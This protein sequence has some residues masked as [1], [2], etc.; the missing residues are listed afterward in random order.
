MSTR[1][2]LLSSTAP[3]A[4]APKLIS[5]NALSESLSYA[6]IMKPK[7]RPSAGILIPIK[8][9]VPNLDDG[10]ISALNTYNGSRLTRHFNEKWMGATL[11]G[12]FRFGSVYS[13]RGS[14]TQLQGRF[15]D[16]QEGV[17]SETFR[18]RTG[19]YSG[20]V[21]GADLQDNIISGYDNPVE[22]RYEA[23]DYCS[24][25][26]IGDFDERRA[27]TLRERG[28]PDIN[29]YVVY[30]AKKLIS[31]IREM[32]SES[33]DF[34]DCAIFAQKVLYGEKNRHWKVEGFFDDKSQKDF[35]AIWLEIV[36]VKSPDYIHEQEVRIVIA[37]LNLAGRLNTECTEY[38]FN[39][40][41]ISDSIVQ[42]GS[43]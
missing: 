35:L 29:R 8:V 3:S 41:R 42:S 43:F 22:L 4:H 32:M 18:S 23:N 39:D 13:Y 10:L 5:G 2:K 31:T 6:H 33:P 27:L 20:H 1:S 15:S 9:D 16:Y 28:N 14:D 38:L 24:C 40:R 30:D 37:S 25:S 7:R 36:F 17:Q 11:E 26:S 19:L 21:G 12:S 34:K